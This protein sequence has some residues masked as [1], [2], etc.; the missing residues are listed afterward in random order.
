VRGNIDRAPLPER[1][2]VEAAGVR[3]YVLH[4]LHELDVDPAAAGYRI[5]V[6]GHSH[7]PA[8]TEKTGVLYINPGAA[9]PRRFQLP[10]TIAGLELG[11]EPWALEFVDVA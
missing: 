3:I 1:A 8:R 11:T 4:N 2:T 9:G 6:S 5:V 10:I 7:R